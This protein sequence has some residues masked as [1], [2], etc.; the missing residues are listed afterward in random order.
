MRRAVL[1]LFV[2]GLAA[3]SSEEKAPTPPATGSTAAPVKKAPGS[4]AAAPA[5]AAAPRKEKDPRVFH[6][7]LGEPE[8]L[9]PGLMSESEGG[10]VAHDTFEGLY[11]YGPSHKEWPEG[12]A[13]SME[14]SPDG[15]TLTFHLRKTAKWSDGQPVTAKDFEFAW[16]RV[17][18]PKTAS[19]YSAIMWVIEG[20]EAYNQSKE[21][22]DRA[23]LRD[24]MGVKALDDYTLQVKLVAPTPY[25]KQLAAFYTF[26]PVPQHVVEKFGDQWAR[27]EHIVSNGP[28]HVT[29]WKSQQDIVA[30]KNDF[31]WDKDKLPFDKIVYEITQENQPAYNMYMAGG[32]DFLDSK[33]PETEITRY[34]REKN[35]ELR[36]DPYITVYL[37]VFN[38]ERKP[39]DDPKVRE[40]LNLA[41]DKEKIGKF[42]I[43][44]GQLPASTIVPPG[45][46]EV[47]YK[48]PEGA[49]FDPEQARKLLAEAGYANGQGFPR[50]QISYNTLEGHKLIAE[51]IQQQWKKNLGIDC[52]LD[53]MEWKVLL[54]KQQAH[55]FA[56]TRY[57]WTGDYIDPMTFLDLWQA[58]NPN[59][60]TG[61][62]SKEFD[63][64]IGTARMEIDP[65]KRMDELK[66]AESLFLKEMPAMPI[67]F[68][69]KQDLVKPWLK[70]YEP[71]LQGLHPS[72]YFHIEQ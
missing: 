9:D 28:W 65:V 38:T 4:E 54:K 10:I 25:F 52:D 11:Q 33:V 35:P 44:G 39:F 8:Y 57:A 67:Y 12:V 21:T 68:Y 17:Q 41:I 18:D 6:R 31:Y 20:A 24:A 36:L 34:M 61:W 72:R 45:L 63:Q 48:G 71:H 70:G 23:K 66:Q 46:S 13:E 27:P 47:G 60:V 62:K 56:V 19:R 43:K 15:K 58:T 42:V 7:S 40:A 50:F 53:N 37:Y 64:L 5:E 2:L 26:A 30:V 1:A 16:K 22:D 69:V 49:E 59:N 14:T 3:C 51:F 32:L 29:E 55:D